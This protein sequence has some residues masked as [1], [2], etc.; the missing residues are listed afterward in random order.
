MRF[1]VEDLFTHFDRIGNGRQNGMFPHVALVSGLTRV[2]VIHRNCP[3]LAWSVTRSDCTARTCMQYEK[4]DPVTGVR[5][6]LNQ[7]ESLEELSQPERVAEIKSR[8]EKLAADNEARAVPG[9]KLIQIFAATLDD[10]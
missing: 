4:V 1:D 7:S 10:E 9:Q 5:Y 8:H 6:T 3:R 2:A